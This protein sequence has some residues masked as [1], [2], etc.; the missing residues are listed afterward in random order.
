MVDMPRRLVKG[1]YAG[2]VK[3]YHLDLKVPFGYSRKD[4]GI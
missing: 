3:N 2:V 4:S 1:C